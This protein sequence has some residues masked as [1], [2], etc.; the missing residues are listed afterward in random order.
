MIIILTPP[1][2]FSIFDIN[3]II[4]LSLKDLVLGYINKNY[5]RPQTRSQLNIKSF[6]QKTKRNSFI[7]QFNR[8]IH[9]T[10]TN[11]ILTYDT[12]WGPYMKGTDYLVITPAIDFLADD[13]EIFKYRKFKYLPIKRLFKLIGPTMIGNKNRK[14][15]LKVVFIRLLNFY[16]LLGLRILYNLYHRIYY[17]NPNNELTLYKLYLTFTANRLF[18]NL[19]NRDGISR[20]Y[21]SLSV[22]LFLKFFKNKKSFKK[23]KLIKVLLIKY[24]RKLLIVSEIRD[25]FLFIKKTPVFFTELLK[26]LTTP[27]IC[28]FL[29]P[30]TGKLY[31]DS[32]VNSKI[33]FPNIKYLIF[34]KTKAYGYMKGAKR[35]RL[36][37]KIMRRIIRTN[38]MPD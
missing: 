12:V 23:N 34:S 18:I 26:T 27:V 24:L 17:L 21:L 31:D 14:Y 3:L 4:I 22:G 15:D 20:N 2:F 19:F 1:L 30:H 36:K 37:R 5:Y 33:S 9:F 8:N 11:I 38:R 13:M 16:R 25:I 28:P 29:H 10:S 6:Y 35:G 32:M 7:K